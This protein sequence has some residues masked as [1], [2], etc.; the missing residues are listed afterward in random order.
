MLSVFPSGRVFLYK[1]GTDKIYEISFNEKEVK[2]HLV[3]KSTTALLE[4]HNKKDFAV[5][6][7]GKIDIND[8]TKGSSCGYIDCKDE[9]YN[10][11]IQMGEDDVLIT[12]SNKAVKLWP[13]KE[14]KAEPQ[15]FA[16]SDRMIFDRLQINGKMLIGFSDKSKTI[17]IWDI[18]TK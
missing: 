13:M 1:Q 4:L 12:A 5:A 10:T 9:I 2:S 14:S 6:S 7:E 16:K 18:E 15:V 8:P 17:A 11:I 3:K